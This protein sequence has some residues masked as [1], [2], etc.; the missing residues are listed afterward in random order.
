MRIK[1]NN[2]LKFTISLFITIIF[3]LSLYLTQSN[4]ILGWYLVALLLI[5]Y[6]KNED[7][8]SEGIW[9]K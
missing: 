1:M 9:H 8:K 3:G 2:W 5:V 6:S 4:F 7:D